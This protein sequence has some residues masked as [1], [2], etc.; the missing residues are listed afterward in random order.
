[1]AQV[2]HKEIEAF[3]RY[4][5]PTPIE[6]ELRELTVKLIT[7]A[8]QQAFPDAEVHPFGSY[9]TKLY[10]PLGDIDLV[11]LSSSMGYSRKENV[12]QAIAKTIKRAGIA[13]QVQIIAKA[14]VPLV[15]FVTSLG[16]LKV[17]MSINQPSG[18]VG[19]QIV[20]GFLKDMQSSLALRSL[21]YITKAFLSQRNMNE[22]Y[23]GGLGSYAIVC[24]VISFLQMHPKIR[25]G[26][27]DPDKNLGV[28]V[29]EFFELYGCY[30]NYQET[31]ISIRDGGSYYS[32]KQRGWFD[33]YKP[34]SLS[35][36]DPAD[37]TNDISS[38]S[39]AFPKVRTTFAG[40][41]GI[42]TAS[43]YLK[44]GVLEARLSDSSTRLRG[45][46]YPEDLSL[47]SSIL[48]VTQETIN[49]R[50]MTLEL[51]EERKLH[52]LLGV[53]PK[54]VVVEYQEPSSSSAKAEE[55]TNDATASLVP[56]YVEAG[57]EDGE[58]HPI[59]DDNEDEDDR[60]RYGIG[61]AG[62]PT[63]RRKLGNDHDSHVVFT[64]DDEDDEEFA[65]YAVPSSDDSQ[66]EPVARLNGSPNKRPKVD[67]QTSRDYWLS[68]GI[69]PDT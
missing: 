69:G 36:E 61:E 14:R 48:G 63:K 58:V 47:L 2:F 56:H 29:F 67:R 38:G 5:S 68:K 40:A 39:F 57:S 12:L 46:Y 34:I 9:E 62:P 64:T 18:L 11:I 10:L 59:R 7:N 19:G 32:K 6:A 17:D 15:K 21:V 22:V 52:K 49:H 27:I 26:E 60:G 13:S 23:T 55:P 8:V 44:A 41:F 25:N 20:K 50:K 24:L 35:I 4:I 43:A 30:F 16:M 66:V 53:N 51:Y 1:M 42:L 65:A 3:T 28:L 37:E 33:Y 31:G 45:R 54:P